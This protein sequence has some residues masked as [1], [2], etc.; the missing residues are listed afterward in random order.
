MQDLR[1]RITADNRATGPLREVDRALANVGRSAANLG[2]LM[3]P[4]ATA[5]A[6]IGVGLGLQQ[7]VT[8]FAEAEAR[9]LKLE[10]TVK[11][12]G[13]AAGLTAEELRTMAR[14][15]ALSTLESVQGAETAVAQLLTFKAVG[16]DAFGTVLNLAADLSALGFGSLESNVVRL[17][18]ALENPVI[19]IQ[20][21]REAGVSFTDAQR[22]N[23]PAIGAW[24]TYRFRGL[25]DSGL[26]R[27]ASFVRVRED[28]NPA[29]PQLASVPGSP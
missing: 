9:F 24:V 1:I 3:Q 8:S 11:A 6:S 18:K 25:H 26:P 16:K 7:I 17:G 10:Q 20:A 29:P 23:P 12:T 22:H 2:S 28:I 21:L 13:N 15:L 14:E 27:F 5:F 4:L 19:G